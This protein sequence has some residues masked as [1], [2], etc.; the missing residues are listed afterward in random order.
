MQWRSVDFPAPDGLHDAD[1][2]AVTDLE[3]YPAQD[4]ESAPHVTKRLVH[5]G[6][7]DD[8][9]RHDGGAD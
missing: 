9:R 2:L 7:D 5:V 6:G 4:L 3:V 8:G 1:D